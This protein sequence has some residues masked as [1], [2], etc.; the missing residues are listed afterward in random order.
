[1]ITHRGRT[2]TTIVGRIVAI[3]PQSKPGFGNKLVESAVQIFL[4]EEAKRT[5]GTE[6]TLNDMLKQMSKICDNV[7]FTSGNNQNG[8]ETSMRF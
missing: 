8:T 2:G 1:M 6:T 7:R 5:R 4:V 3:V